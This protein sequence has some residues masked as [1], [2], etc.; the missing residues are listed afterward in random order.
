MADDTAFCPHCDEQ[1][2]IR[3]AGCKRAIS[4][5][6]AFCPECGLALQTAGPIKVPEYTR[7]RKNAPNQEDD[8]FSGEC[9]NCSA[10]LYVEDGFCNECGQALCAACGRSIDESDET[11]P[12]CGV[13]LFFSCPLCDFEL[14]VG[15]E[16]CPNC[17]A[18]FPTACSHCGGP[19]QATD[20]RCQ[21]CRRPVVI[22]RRHSARTIHSFLV[23]QQLVRMIACPGCGRH[24]NPATGPCTACGDRVCAD[25]Q[26]ILI[27]DER[28]C[29]RCGHAVMASSS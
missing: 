2:L 18:L 16:M 9:P 14:T 29:P 17:D 3:C 5:S 12:A 10:E 25:C 26:L 4:R 20:T 7:I 1:L 19:L 11:C 15:T 6:A 21:S 13:K 28:N 22:Q 27:D 24:L 8:A 23:G